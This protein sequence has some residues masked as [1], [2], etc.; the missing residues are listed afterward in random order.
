MSSATV[1][2]IE[3]GISVGVFFVG[4]GEKYNSLPITG[5]DKKCQISSAQLGNDALEVGFLL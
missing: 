5:F 4:E 1:V 3:F 2:P